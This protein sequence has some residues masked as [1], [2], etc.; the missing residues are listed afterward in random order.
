MPAIEG[1]YQPFEPAYLRNILIAVAMFFTDVRHMPLDLVLA[2]KGLNIL[3][4]YLRDRPSPVPVPQQKLPEKATFSIDSCRS[5]ASLLLHPH[6]EV[7]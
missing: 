1:E 5:K 4:A 2:K 6:L 3:K 7:L